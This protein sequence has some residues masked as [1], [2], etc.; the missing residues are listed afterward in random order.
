ME[1]RRQLR[2][3]LWKDYLIRKRKAIT[4]AGLIW[5][6]AVICSLHIVRVNIDNTE[7]PTCGFPA[8]A[9]PS[10]GMVPFLQSFLCS[11][12]N[13]CSSL[14]QY[15]EI[16]TYENSKLTKV[17][18]RMGPF[19]NESTLEVASSVPDALKLV[20]TL[21][22]TVDEPTFVKISKNGLH[23]E[24]LFIKPI[25]VKRFLGEK[26]G[27]DDS[28]MESI[29]TAELSFQGLLKGSIDRC[30]VESLSKTL[31]MENPEHLSILKGKLCAM[32]PEELQKIF[33]NILPELD[34]SKY[35]TMLGDMYSKLSGDNRII[36]L[37]DMLTAVLRMM[38][39]QSFLPPE[40]IS[41]FNGKEVDFSYIQ[42]TLIPK[43]MEKFKPIFGD[44]QSYGILR[45][46]AD[47]LVVGLQ[48]LDKLFK[49]MRV[50]E[51]DG[52]L[53]PSNINIFDPKSGMEAISNALNHASD[54]FE[55]AI[56][57]DT[58]FDAFTA[59]TYMMNFV[60]K[61]L[62]ANTKHDVLFYS[63]LLSKL[64]ESASRV[65]DI[66]MHIESL[67]YNVTLQHPGAVRILQGMKPE[68]I[69]SAFEGLADAERAQILT[70]KINSPEKMFCNVDKLKQ[71]LNIADVIEI[72]LL[73]KQLCTDVWNSYIT[74]M[75]QAFGVSDVKNNINRMASLL[76]QETLG[77]DTSSQL[78]TIEQ[79]FQIL[80]NFT[81]RL[82]TLDS[83]NKPKAD[84]EKLLNM[85]SDSEFMKMIR[86]KGHLGKQMLIVLHGALGKE[87]VQQN[88]LL[89]F[90]ISP[91]L[92]NVIALTSGIN[93]QLELTPV[94]VTDLI[95]DNYYGIVMTM[96]RTALQEEKT[97][98]S[99][100]TPGQEI[101]CNDVETARQYL[102][103]PEDANEAAEIVMALCNATIIIENGLSEDSA[104]TKAIKA[105]KS[106]ATLLGI[107]W[108]KLINN[109]KTLYVNLDTD[110]TY[111]FNFSNYGMDKTMKEDLDRL[112]N[113]AKDYWFGVAN[114]ERGLRLSMKLALRFL[115]LLD[116]DLFG[117]MNEYWLKIKYAINISA[118]PMDV[119]AES[120]HV[121]G[122]LLTNK[123]YSGDLPPKTVDILRRLI[124][125][126]PQ[127]T[128]EAV[129]IIKSDDIEIQ[130]IISL[131][132]LNPPWPCSSMSLSEL[133]ELSQNS[134]EAVR[135]VEAI[136]CINDEIQQE[137]KEYLAQKNFYVPVK[138][139]SA[140]N[141]TDYPPNL[142]LK[143]SSNIDS[144]IQDIVIVRE[145]LNH[146]FNDS[147]DGH[148]GLKE[149]WK[150]AVDTFN[151][152]DRDVILRNFFTKIDTV[153]DSVNTSSIASNVSTSHLW[154]GFVKCSQ[155][156]IDED[157]RMLGRKS[158]KYF[159]ESLSVILESVATDLLT[160]FKE[161][162]EPNANLLQLVGFNRNTGLYTLYDKLPDF[163][164]VLLN[165]YWDFGFMSQ[166]RRASFSK[167]WDCNAIVS[168]LVPPPGSV[169]DEASIE[170]VKPFICPTLLHWLS[171]PR[172]ENT[173]LDVFSKPQY[174]F[175]TL[176]VQNITSRY[177]NAYMKAVELAQLITDISKKNQTVLT[178]EDIKINSIEGKL[179]KTVDKVLTY[180]M[181]A[182][183]FSYRIFTTINYKQFRA[184]IYL[185]RIVAIVNKLYENIKNIDVKNTF[186]G[187]D[188]ELKDLQADIDII[189]YLFKRKA[190]DAINIHFNAITDILVKNNKDYTLVES[191][192]DICEDIKSNISR[193][194]ISMDEKIVGQ[195]CSKKY[196]V[197]Y[198]AIQ[199]SLVEDY[200]EA[201]YSLM[202]LVDSLQNS[203]NFVEDIFGFLNNRTEL[204][205]ALQTSINHSYDLGIPVYLKYLQSNIQAYGIVLSFLS[206]NDWWTELRTVYNGPYTEKF[207]A[208]VEN[209]FEVIE[210]LMT[211]LDD[212][213]IVRLLREINVNDTDSFCQPNIVLSDYL[214]DS[215]GMFTDMKNQICNKEKSEL[216]KEL[217]PLLFASQGLDSSLK[218]SKVIDY[219]TLN[220][221]V[222]MVESRL[223]LIKEGPKVPLY[224]G[225]VTE[226]KLQHLRKVALGLLSKQSLTKMGFAVLSNGVDAATLFLSGSHCTVCSQL[227]TWLKQLNLQLFKKQEYDNLLC[228]L[229]GMTL[230]DVHNTL[231]TDFHWD[232][233]LR[234][235]IST[236]NYTKYEMNK[237]MGE[238]IGLVKLYL[239]EDIA[240]NTTKLTECLARNISRNEIGNA[241]LFASVLAQTGKLLRA[242]LPH[243]QEVEGVRDLPYLKEIYEEIAR[244]LD[245]EKPLVDYLIENNALHEDLV[246]IL[247]SDVANDIEDSKIN[248]RNIRSMPDSLTQIKLP[249]GNWNVVCDKYNCSEIASI[250]KEY[251]NN[252]K[253]DKMLPKYQQEEFWRFKFVSNIIQR[254]EGLV[255]HIA[256]LLGVA[257]KLDLAGLRDGKLDA[258]L[259]TGLL[260]IK[261][262][263]LDSIG[264]SLQGLIAEMQPLMETTPLDKDLQALSAGLNV[265]RQFK[266]YLLDKINPK[267]EVKSLFLNPENIEAGLSALGI[268]NTN[269]WSIAAPRIYEGYIHLKPLFTSKQDNIHISMY[270]CQIDAMSKVLKPSN[271]DVVTAED[272]LAA[273][274]DQFCG[275]PDETAKQILPVLL[276]NFNFK[277]ILDFIKTT[278][279]KKLYE[280]SNLTEDEGASVLSKY[281]QMVALVPAIQDNIGYV[282]ELFA[283]EPMF[284]SFKEFSSI[285]SLFSSKEFLS[286]AG[287]CFCGKPFSVNTN[288]IY[289]QMVATEDLSTKP[290]QAQLDALPNDY[291]RSLYVDIVNVQG[292]KIV[293]SFIKPLI[294]GKILYTPPNPTVNTIMEKA[295]STF[296]SMIKVVNLVHS[297]AKSFPAVNKM[298]SHRDGVDVLRNVMTSPQFSAVRA[299]IVDGESNE[300][301]S[302]QDFNVDGL[303]HEFGD[304]EDIGTLLSKASDILNCINLNRIQATPNEYEL[305]H[306]AAVLSTVNEF[307]AGVV[308]LNSEELD[309]SFSNVEYKIR[310]DIDTV[311]TTKRLKD[312]LWIPG[313]ESNFIENM[314]YFRGFV[315]L[316]DIVDKAIIQ[317][318]AENS[319][320]KTTTEE[321]D[322]A[323]Y[324]QQTPY[325]CY[326]ADLF[327]T[328][329]YESQSLIVAFFFSLLFS[330]ASTVRF[331]V[332]D[333]ESGNTMLMSV[334]GVDLRWHTL[335]WFIAS[336]IEMT[337]TMVCITIILYAGS[338]L[339]TTDPSLVFVLLFIFGISMLSF[340]YMISKM[341]QS[342][343]LAAV[344]GAITYLV[345]FMPIV[346][347]LSL[348]TVLYNSFKLVICLSMSSSL[349]YAFLYI[350][351]YEAHGAGAG[352]AQLW[353]SPSEGED[354]SIGLATLMM[355]VDAVIYFIIGW[356]IDRYFG[357][358]TLKTNI[359]HCTTTN[360]KAGVSILNV[361]KVYNERSRRPKL[362]LDNVSIELHKGQITTL[363]GHN[364]AGKTTLIN[365]LTGMLKPTKGHVIIRSEREA[366][367]RLG[368]CPQHDV[369]FEHM[370]ARE[371]VM[372][373]AQLKGGHGKGELQAEVDKM[374]EVLSLGPVSSELVCRLSGGT[375]RRLCVALAFVGAPHLVSLD[376][377]TAG[378]D[379]A[380]R[381]DIWSMIVKL[382]EDKTILMTTHHLDEAELLSDQI[383]IMHKGQ[384]HTTGSPIEIKRT[385]GNGYK[386]TV[387]YPERADINEMTEE[388]NQEEKT[389]QLLTVVR[390]VVKNANVIDVNELEVEIG[391]PFFDMNGLNN[392]FLQLCSVLEAIQPALG[393][394]SF[395]MDCSSL[396]QVFFNV[397]Q[398]ADTPLTN[399][400][401]TSSE[402]FPSKSASSSSIRTDRT[403]QQLVPPE[404]PMKGSAWE[405]FLALMYARYLHHIRNRWL[406]F[407]LIILPS[408]FVTIAMGFSMLRP[409][410]D[411]EISLKLDRNLYVNTTDFIVPRPS[412]SSKTMDAS[413][414]E[415][416]MEH[417]MGG[418]HIK[419]WTTEDSP[420]CECHPKHQVCNAIPNMTVL[421]DMMALPDVNS[422]N[423]W[424]VDTQEIFIEKRY[425]GYSSSL[426]ND[427]TNLVVWYN[428]KGHHAMVS[429]LNALNTAILRART[430]TPRASIT[431]YTH[432]LKIS[433]EQL[434]KATVYQHIAD[435]GISGLLL[436]AYA[437][438]SAGAAIYLVSSRRSQE[439]RLQLLCGVSP[440]LYWTTALVWDM[441]IMA[442]NMGITA[443]VMVAFGFPVFVSRNNLPAICI[444]F[445]LYGYACG[446]LI[447][448]AEK[449]F[450]EASMANM[451]LFC[452]NAF[453]GLSFIAILLIFDVISESE[454]T[455]N[456]RYVLH[457]IF[458]L[459]PQFALGDGL[460][461]IAKNT[462]QAQVLGRFGMDTY[463]DPLG[464]N[465]ITLHYSY[466]ALVGTALM[467]LNLAIE[468]NCF[469]G[470]L[471][472]FRSVSIPP[473]VPGE[474]EPI[475]VTEERKRV[476]STRL[477][478]EPTIHGVSTI[479]N[480]NRGYVH[481]EG[482]KNSIQRV[483]APLSDV[484]QCVALSKAYRGVRAHTVALRDLTLGILPSQCTALLG[485][486]GAGKS[487]TFSLL[488][489]EIRPT[490][491]QIYLNNK[492]VNST[493]LCT[494][495][496]SYC[497]QSDAIDSLL[498]VTEILRFY[499]RLRGI[500]DYEQVVARALDMFELVQYAHVRS[501]ALSGGNKR[502]LCAAVAFMARTPLVLLDEPTRFGG[503]GS[504]RGQ[505]PAGRA[506]RALRGADCARAPRTRLCAC[507]NQHTLHVLIPTHATEAETF[508]M[509]IVNIRRNAQS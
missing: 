499:C 495:L 70:S 427:V 391:L 470:L 87:I 171:V 395:T 11:A 29:M 293:W 402:S 193:T 290:D 138:G 360:E 365:I 310:M 129:D 261:D 147:K 500:T 36:L 76:I 185:T 39:L 258:L 69:G 487:T 246:S 228:H 96:M 124:P 489:G 52:G 238:F 436:I 380:A 355:L 430:H 344:C 466:L 234:E 6:S 191:M 484:A 125:N 176:Q 144:L 386:L 401:Y 158:W 16:P 286:S 359:T 373:Y 172:G 420:T 418:R 314:R 255:S 204:I 203:D 253:I 122:A 294:M 83:E 162:N 97:Y 349:C 73:K 488:T 50:K 151:T 104:V 15:E 505:A 273:V 17:M 449:L 88:G 156:Y 89:D 435:A 388:I 42:L 26:L 160:Y 103:L 324:T 439:K 284:K 353:D 58:S 137:W 433:K 417:L 374:L 168:S 312:F 321:E 504:P 55:E 425:G 281:S 165:S 201:R 130:P 384:I 492:I 177:A 252:S 494:G 74:D 66:N 118:G 28:I 302:V 209:S 149:A 329:L 47:A 295:N 223:D 368:V 416:I 18:R 166:I 173:L 315:E 174:F 357:I 57:E 157:C 24:D 109:L 119:F 458:L 396:E 350:T 199:N 467:L 195:L 303:F 3:L 447:H 451:V 426:K 405:Q 311:P 263:I 81:E 54:V 491:G 126:I 464:T 212:I 239:L 385:L 476:H 369:L 299:L 38:N 61:F 270:M 334:M 343:S 297:F 308:F 509:L 468:Y 287:S 450:S 220:T 434:S 202:A 153:L 503:W 164:G 408:L 34:Y 347:I 411:N 422:L 214:P 80:K 363:L 339:P 459:A 77:K 262:D 457:K 429:H 282:S 392:N 375:R 335:S 266:Y 440:L 288:K 452:G 399:I 231:K 236:R 64:I 278:L 135:S 496:I 472:R 331:I 356:L 371:H 307:S 437:L 210:N 448:V 415:R 442:I 333:K 291:C 421:P 469:E 150:Y 131:M 134:T 98:K 389:K 379:P 382:K 296:A 32:S 86:R 207:F 390:D 342:A 218:I 237:S 200:P 419:N 127:L 340:C 221:N 94:D 502:K 269:F 445:L 92:D 95:K 224:P 8:R 372:L 68:I 465:L 128:V 292:G 309:D 272:V 51:L 79:D 20:S 319:L 393:F 105:F 37:G 186:K 267:I 479:G 497:P 364:G 114:V 247:D 169:I 40:L 67:T 22:D 117:V 181:N 110:Y 306:A 276:K 82:M 358:R 482:F 480:I 345:T 283:D 121:I 230:D 423:K 441:L 250:L 268:N 455:D 313:P 403:P 475:E 170:K 7:Y 211:N 180:K 432:P 75:I 91:Y 145:T 179:E 316:Q 192:Y 100:S 443:A 99:L 41:I 56:Q 471:V 481:T 25:S 289:K 318:S 188:E 146:V 208:Y 300:G 317:L 197:I 116:H 378:V 108:I 46:V 483:V 48:Y 227:T 383:V 279:L 140:W 13:Q 280:A 113:M 461:E 189:K 23:V 325:P 498:S 354:M 381:R 424:L 478:A 351:R 205:K 219:T 85:S 152:S 414:A 387:M 107:D 412:K 106:S 346:I 431:T 53:T 62:S 409:P 182:S 406:L 10:A 12:D 274:V 198:G 377:P 463:Q 413:F 154:E 226:E 251:L 304:V 397:C 446:S 184:G 141:R 327:Q 328:G 235:L 275:L 242:E 44:T 161:I 196:E 63:T 155:E 508:E 215:T 143:F 486:N 400:E 260:L 33:I 35:M 19:L 190:V 305:T 428:N 175:Y 361:S 123:M 178:E 332:S 217:P 90:K 298:L 206:G 337:V 404:G 330:V 507:C 338:I 245:V 2:L 132:N 45:N 438:I 265:L 249:R 460:L 112:Y 462:I 277:P 59:L 301:V 93:E 454:E 111:V 271:L 485:Q 120:I 14:D 366:G 376:E 348:E 493:Q 4:L 1:G 257:S 31:V 254:I 139:S 490:S 71:F 477:Q 216:Y 362:A 367:T 444:M 285:G 101:M 370:S 407:M 410:A 30:S 148:L 264:Y 240:A 326:T 394:K 474:L 322:W 352:W 115:D 456:A 187:T 27:L 506:R 72:E 136:F 194:I 336:F 65:I 9:L 78:Y 159:F 248:L 43:I 341:F 142:F 167:F 84:W 256:R 60:T 5:A 241:T 222:S 323:V 473:P 229:Q 320:S 133:L 233:A 102:E 259:D 163:V 232:M 49:K 501:G 243:I 244:H 183:D 453:L 21:A 225:W 213:H 398:Q